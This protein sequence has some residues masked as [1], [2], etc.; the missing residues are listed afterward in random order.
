MRK[1]LFVLLLLPAL[2]FAGDEAITDYHN[3]S[4]FLPQTPS[5]TGGA[6]AAFFNPAGWSANDVNNTSFYWTDKRINHGG[7]ENWGFSSGH[8]LGFSV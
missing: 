3:T 2:L 5:V 7:M 1:L 6:T 4:L 8:G